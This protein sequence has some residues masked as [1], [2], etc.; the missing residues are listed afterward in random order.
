[1]IRAIRRQS[2][3]HR[4]PAMTHHPRAGDDPGV[5]EATPT[6]PKETAMST[7]PATEPAVKTY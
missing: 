1:V 5:T 6:T 7:I 2:L 4:H 3:N